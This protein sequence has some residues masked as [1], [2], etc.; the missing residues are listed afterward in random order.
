MYKYTITIILTYENTKYI[1][2]LPGAIQ[3]MLRGEFNKGK[4]LIFTKTP[5]EDRKVIN[6][7]IYP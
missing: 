2:L 4:L 5:R 1:V 6:R 3:K 7:Q